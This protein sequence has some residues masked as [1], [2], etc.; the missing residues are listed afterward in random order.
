MRKHDRINQTKNNFPPLRIT[1]ILPF[2]YILIELGIYPFPPY[3]SAAA[4][5]WEHQHQH[6]PG[7][8]EPP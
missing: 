7:A 2:P 6:P 5:C 8:I 3:T 4:V 1:R